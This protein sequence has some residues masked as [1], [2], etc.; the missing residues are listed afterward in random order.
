MSQQDLNFEADEKVPSF[1]E[2]MKDLEG[3]VKK[4]EENEVPLEEAITLFQK[5]MSL[6]KLCHQKLQKVENQ[7]DHILQEDGSMHPFKL[8]EDDRS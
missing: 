6:S 2:A 4:L 5:G 1:E 3:I 7:M 8:Q